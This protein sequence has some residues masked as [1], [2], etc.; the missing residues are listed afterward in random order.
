MTSAKSTG[1]DKRSKKFSVS[2]SMELWREAAIRW[3]AEL[4]TGKKPNQKTVR[5]VYLMTEMVMRS[6][7]HQDNWPNREGPPK[8]HIPLPFAY[9]FANQ[10]SYLANGVLPEPMRD[11]ISGNRPKA[12]PHE[13]RD[14]GRAVAY[15]AAVRDRFI[16]DP[17]PIKT[18][19]EAF[20][21]WPRTVKRWRKKFDWVTSRDFHPHASDNERGALI[22]KDM[23]AAARR[24]RQVGRSSKAV[25]RRNSKRR[26]TK[27]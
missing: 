20:E 8:E 26:A 4:A 17:S 16:D 7:C 2:D 3:D 9:Y 14:I 25:K 11:A 27:G 5:D 18:I 10:V 22:A 24:Y 1:T 12:G 6:Y 19:A 23:K 13:L 21:V 15:I